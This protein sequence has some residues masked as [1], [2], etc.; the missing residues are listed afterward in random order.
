MMSRA[1]RIERHSGG[2]KSKGSLVEAKS[3]LDRSRSGPAAPGTDARR[4]VTHPNILLIV[5]D[6]LRARAIFDASRGAKLPTISGL[7][8]R[9]VSFSTCVA[10]ATTTSPSIATILTG[11]LPFIHGVRQLHGDKLNSDVQTIAELL[12]ARGYRTEAEVTG[13][14]RREKGFQRGFDVFNH[15]S[16]QANLYDAE[17]WEIL[18]NRIRELPKSRPWFFYLHL[19]EMHRPRTVPVA[20]DRRKYG[21][22]R[23]ERALSALDQT[24][25]QQILDLAGPESI[26]T[27]TG[28][29]GEI[30]RFDLLLRA[31]QRVKLRPLVH[32]I[33]GN[34]GHGNNVRED[35]V[36]V[37]LL[38]SGPGIP[39]K[40]R[41]DVAVRHMDIFPTIIELVGMNDYHIQQSTGQSLTPL[42]VGRGD[43]RPGYS[44]A[45]RPSYRIGPENWLISLRHK[46]WKLVRRATEGESML[47]R[48]PDERRDVA[49]EHP[50]V[51]AELGALLDIMRSGASLSATGEELSR[52][53][54][55]AIEEHL[56]ELG[57]LD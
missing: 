36:I 14:I 45:V 30:P 57:Y 29:H 15:R 20:F 49:Q 11:T 35:Q 26:V 31:S 19:W 5:I 3:G 7:L 13:P 43:D 47:W 46:G 27:L 22:H 8:G 9:G 16:P 54:A 52:E 48:L 21:R 4:V 41:S 10:T 39:A 53:D 38:I 1:L 40:G 32:L 23:Y 28:D 42:F 33:A 44:E 12:H 25:L 34:S 18:Q 2:P 6:C 24:R 55:D 51:V 37:P 56:K 17:F 50:D